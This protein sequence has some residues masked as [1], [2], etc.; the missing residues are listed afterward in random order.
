VRG[1]VR[2][3]GGP[4]GLVRRLWRGTMCLVLAT[5]TWGVLQSIVDS[6]RMGLR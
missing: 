4:R 3:S 6:M 1:F 5:V 2:P